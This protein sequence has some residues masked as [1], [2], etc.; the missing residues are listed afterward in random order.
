M[1]SFLRN[2]TLF[3][4]AT[5]AVTFLSCNKEK[6]F[7][8]RTQNFNKE[9]KFF[10]GDPENA[11]NRKYNDSVW[12]DLNLPHDWSI[13]G[14]FSKDHPA[15]VGGG[16]LPGGIGWYRKTFKIPE[17]DT[18]K[19]IFIDFDGIYRKSKV[20]INGHLLGER[21]FGYISFRY[22]LT[23]WLNYG[24]KTNVIAVRVDNSEQPNSRWYSGSGIYRNVR[25]VTTHKIHIDHWGTFITTPNVTT[26][27]AEV[28]I[29]IRVANASALSGDVQV[30]T[31]IYSPEGKKIRTVT[32]DLNIP[33][34]KVKTISQKV[35][36]SKPELWSDVK[37]HMYKAYTFLKSDGETIDQYMT[38][39]GIRTFSFDL[40]KGFILN[41]ESVKIKGVCNH[42][43]LGCLGAAVNKR[44]IE[45]Q[46]EILKEMGCNGIRTSHNPPAPELLDLC[47]R[48]GFIVMDEAFDCWALNKTTYGY[49]EDFSTWGKRDLE[50]MIRRDRN[51]PSI[52][53]WSIGNEI[54][55]QWDT[56]GTRMAAELVK[57][58]KALDTTREIT[59]GLN[60]PQ[61]S[62]Y[63]IKSDAF[64]L[65]GYNYKH[66]NFKTFQDSFP[67]KKFIAAETTSALATRGYYEMP[68]DTIRRWPVHWDI[69]FTDGNP[70]NTVSAYD[71]VSTPWGS[72][73]EE[74][75]KIVKKYDFLSG[76]Y[77]WTGF[78]YLGEPTP[79]GW[80]SRSS[81]F[82]IIDL[83]GF[84]KDAYYMY[85]SEWTDRPVLHV[86]PHWNWNTG[87]TIDIWAYYNKA[88]TVE[89]FL[90]GKSLGVLSKLKEDLHVSWRVP[91]KKGTL[92]AVSKKNGKIILSKEIKTAGNP[93]KILLKADR[94]IIQADGI[95]L[96][97]ISIH[98]LD[99]EG[100]FVPDASNKITFSIK[101]NGKIAAV[102]NGD[103]LSH[104]SFKANS[105]KTFNGKCLVVV[106]STEREGKIQLTASSEGLQGASVTIETRK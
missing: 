58:V 100:N 56:S 64:N 77:I 98:I 49:W 80:P 89:L 82:G 23:P 105:R 8:R 15:D 17:E 7:P 19:L 85:Q 24:E 48:M 6:D 25:M 63:I 33:P 87:D 31:L 91:F 72:T 38:S 51:H 37:P 81:Y 11:M 88:D 75:W 46:L 65:I 61:P 20:W 44:A 32:A 101:G 3:F 28:N 73:H 68:S 10:L 22:E 86:F 66:E 97:F 53:M 29:D 40:N 5:I 95:D 103:P 13:E 52:F 102:D 50:D 41:G 71:H 21:P 57:F 27:D 14:E 99:K 1:D 42:H 35:Y 67:G 69:P 36:I 78:D 62:N 54:L 93:S 94:K 90:N 74:T 106:Q 83:A 16:A 104:G 59:S 30:K 39:F 96:S 2:Q 12:R 45:R 18:T 4:L 60:D 92:K 84:P 76:M 79:Y 47:D 70:D 9:W 26:D 55:E 43:D 34:H